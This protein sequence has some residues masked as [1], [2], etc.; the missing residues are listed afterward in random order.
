MSPIKHFTY[1][2]IDFKKWDLLIQN[3]LSDTFYALS[4]FLNSV[5]EDWEILIQGDY[6]SGMF[7]PV[8]KQFGSKLI[9]QPLPMMQLGIFSRVHTI[10]PDTDDFFHSIPKSYRWFQ[11]QLTKYSLVNLSYHNVSQNQC[12]DIDLILTGEMLLSRFSE[13]V[14][15]RIE[16]A[17]QADLSIM[18]SLA[19]NDIIKLWSSSH[20]MSIDNTSMI[21]RVLAR[22][23]QNRMC[24]IWGAYSKY[25]DLVASG[26]FFFYKKKIILSFTAMIQNDG[27]TGLVWIIHKFI[28]EHAEKNLILR[29]EPALREKFSLLGFM[30]KSPDKDL[31][32][33]YK[34]LGAQTNQFPTV[35]SRTYMPLAILFK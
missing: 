6:E 22:G 10:S 27:L 19:P 15:K 11:I 3:S 18:K 35:K 26:V 30:K 33:V 2:Q 13:Q 1:K 32:Q 4:W 31:S 25:N 29:L 23:I 28:E 7:L 17:K 14:S 9:Y 12:F 16:K 24:E 34:G 20:K 5:C 8:R 21:R